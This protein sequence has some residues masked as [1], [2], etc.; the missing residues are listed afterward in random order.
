MFRSSGLYRD[1]WDSRRGNTTYGAETIAKI[2]DAPGANTYQSTNGTSARIIEDFV[3]PAPVPSVDASTP[4]PVPY[5]E[6]DL[7]WVSE[8]TQLMTELTGSPAEFNRLAG[9]AIVA[10]VL[11]RKFKL[12]TTFGDIYPNIY[13]AII[14]PSSVFHKSAAL[15]K[16]AVMLSKAGFADSL[17]ANQFT[18]EGLVRALAA[19]PIGL[20]VND[21]IGRLFTSHKTK[22]LENLKPDLTAYYDGGI[23]KRQLSK[24]TITVNHPCLSIIGAT[25]P[26][27]FFEGV[28][29]LDWQSGFLARWMFAR[30][31]TAEPDFEPGDFLDAGTISLQ[32]SALPE[33]KL[34]TALEKIAAQAPATMNY[35]PGA[36]DCWRNWYKENMKAAYTFGDD[37]VIAFEQRATTYAL[38][39]AIMLTVMDASTVVTQGTMQTAIELAGHYT[40]VARQ[41]MAE[42][43]EWGVGGDKLQK[44]LRVINKLTE[45]KKEASTSVIQKAANMKK[46]EL[47]P[48][49]DALAK[50]G[51]VVREPRHPHGH[52]Y[53]ALVRQLQPRMVNGGEV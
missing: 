11:G 13:G 51:A 37:K 30:P 8:Y 1:K 48:C 3:T 50:A 40:Q 43:Q 12:E 19:Q 10:T 53:I 23:V 18:P 46:A 33:N 34:A 44:V 31:G 41:M 4:A 2:L 16:V 45:D 25:T 17:L 47:E 9:L 32:R 39:F 22:Y 14:A 52:V 29:G 20:I 42:H 49:L 21:E 35:E 24:D 38:K 27:V 26:K 5:K 36:Y 7:R 28:T 6:L 15:G